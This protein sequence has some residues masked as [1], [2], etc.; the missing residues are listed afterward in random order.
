LLAEAAEQQL[1]AGNKA[2]AFSLINSG[3]A[4]LTGSEALADF[5]DLSRPL[6][7]KINARDASAL[8]AEYLLAQHSGYFADKR[9]AQD[10]LTA[11]AAGNA[12]PHSDKLRK[13]LAHMTGFLRGELE[14]LMADH[15]RLHPRTGPSLSGAA[16]VTLFFMLIGLTGCTP[17]VGAVAGWAWVWGVVL[18]MAPL[19]IGALGTFF[20]IR[21]IACGFVQSRAGPSSDAT[22]PSRKTG[23]RPAEYDDVF[24][25]PANA[26]NIRKFLSEARADVDPEQKERLENLIAMVERYLSQPRQDPN[27][28]LYILCDRVGTARKSLVGGLLRVTRRGSEV[29]VEGH[30]IPMS[31]GRC[32]SDEFITEHIVPL[33]PRRI[34]FRHVPLDATLTDG[35]LRSHVRLTGAAGSDSA[36]VYEE[37]R[38]SWSLMRLWEFR[39]NRTSRMY[40]F[41]QCSSW[42]HDYAHYL[43]SG[44]GLSLIWDYAQKTGILGHYEMANNIL[45]LVIPVLLFPVAFR[46]M[47]IA[48]AARDLRTQDEEDWIHRVSKLQS[49]RDIFRAFYYCA[50]GRTVVALLFIALIPQSALVGHWGSFLLFNHSAKVALF[51]MVF[52][53]FVEKLTSTYEET[54]YEE[55]N[56]REIFSSR[57][58][59]ARGLPEADHLISTYEKVF[60]SVIQTTA[61]SLGVGIFNMGWLDAVLPLILISSAIYIFSEFAQVAWGKDYQLFLEIN[62]SGFTV[63][64]NGNIVLAPG[65][66]MDVNSRGHYSNV[67]PIES[68]A[69]AWLPLDGLEVSLVYQDEAPRI[70]QAGRGVRIIGMP[71]Q[72]VISVKKVFGSVLARGIHIQRKGRAFYV[73]LDALDKRNSPGQTLT[74]DIIRAAVEE[75]KR[76]FNA[77]LV[78]RYEPMLREMDST[79]FRSKAPAFT[80]RTVIAEVKARQIEY[81]DLYYHLSPENQARVRSH[82]ST[83]LKN[84]HIFNELEICRLDAENAAKDPAAVSA[85]LA[86]I[87]SEADTISGDDDKVRD[88]LRLLSGQLAR[89]RGQR[90]SSRYSV[91]ARGFPEAVFLQAEKALQDAMQRQQRAA[92]EE[93]R[94]QR[95]AR[96]IAPVRMPPLSPLPAPVPTYPAVVDEVYEQVIGDRTLKRLRQFH[97]REEFKPAAGGH[98]RPKGGMPFPEWTAPVPIDDDVCLEVARDLRLARLEESYY[99]VRLFKS[100]GG[101]F[102]PKGG[103]PFPQWI[104]ECV[105]VMEESEEAAGDEPAADEPAAKAGTKDMALEGRLFEFFMEQIVE[106]AAVKRHQDI[107]GKIE[108]EELREVGRDAVLEVLES[109]G[110]T[111]TEALWLFVGLRVL[112]CIDRHILEVVAS[113]ELKLPGIKAFNLEKTM[114]EL[115]AT[116]AKKKRA[117]RKAERESKKAVEPISLQPVDDSLDIVLKPE[118]GDFMARIVRPLVKKLAGR[119]GD[120]DDVLF[121]AGR[122]ALKAAL[123]KHNAIQRPALDPL[124]EADVERVLRE[125]QRTAGAETLSQVVNKVTGLILAIVSMFFVSGCGREEPAPPAIVS[126]PPA[127]PSTAEL[128]FSPSYINPLAKHWAETHPSTNFVTDQSFY[129]AM[130]GFIYSNLCT[131]KDDPAYTNGSS[132]WTKYIDSNI[133]YP[134]AVEHDDSF[135]IFLEGARA[136]GVKN[137]PVTIERLY[138]LAWE[139]GYSDDLNVQKP[140]NY[141]D[142]VTRLAVKC[143]MDLGPAGI[144]AVA[145]ILSNTNAAARPVRLGVIVEGIGQA[146]TIDP[147]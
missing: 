127:R 100:K 8:K 44:L 108:L 28:D 109:R 94:R 16:S 34:T 55:A 102:R 82:E 14:T 141:D 116:S 63:A 73:V 65:L 118:F 101:H 1:G 79:A 106:P 53:F 61:F 83:H 35:A 71:G 112:Y 20:I 75:G 47:K 81:H 50:W 91:E 107:A 30:D 37:E 52:L 17:A 21:E 137:D 70:E 18:N 89:Y 92:I 33:K 132:L 29:E 104:P 36:A 144:D 139:E 78:E 131:G 48:K 123:R 56:I 95:S 84:V 85:A 110:Q 133:N 96:P 77:A 135:V 45:L 129:S 57:E 58:A 134:W 7:E 3:E 119:K 11:M 32:L 93:M 126:A 128:L 88:R 31:A 6:I 142:R 15:E 120:P 2:G 62:R 49:S 9:I 97:D 66:E 103:M 122:E 130:M 99:L 41:M 40:L 60:A 143:L 114:A 98:F 124:V 117:A 42:I 4:F 27:I 23:K 59:R 68:R 72:P 105:E 64:K 86:A 145:R 80:G 138:Q 51:L 74:Y 10:F 125:A 24:V 5:K 113:G 25:S 22:G 54:H 39:A 140:H 46:V 136:S 111:K 26:D 67:A 115:K 147:L 19:A 87:T 121:E 38:T 12:Y 69:S 90:E 43:V 13:Q 146:A 76:R